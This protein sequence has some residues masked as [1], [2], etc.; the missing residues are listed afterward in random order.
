MTILC[1]PKLTQHHGQV[2]G[3]LPAGNAA[4]A[5]GQGTN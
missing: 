2:N 4:F 5:T 1:A 3:A